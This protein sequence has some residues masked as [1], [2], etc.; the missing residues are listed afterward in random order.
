MFNRNKDSINK[1]ST[2]Q[3]FG[4]LQSAINELFNDFWTDWPR[5]AGLTKRSSEA[6]GE[7]TPRVN[8]R[9]SENEVAI[10]AELPGME[11]KDIDITLKPDHLTIKGE[12]RFEKEEGDPNKDHYYVE[13]SYGSFQ[14]TIPLSCEIDMERSTAKFEKGVLKVNLPKSREAKA[15]SR[16]LNIQG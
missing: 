7:F 6:L 15:N 14:R 2:Q 16:K 4:G 8:V 1:L 9:E 13:R 12:K 11:Q 10:S 3:N 5:G